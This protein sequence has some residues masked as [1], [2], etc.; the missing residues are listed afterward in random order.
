MQEHQITYNG[1]TLSIGSWA[2]K[3]HQP[4][5][6]LV[7]RY[8]RGWPPAQVLG[9]EPRVR[10]TVVRKSFNR[11]SKRY[12]HDGKNLTLKEWAKKLGI[13]VKTIYNRKRQGLPL[14]MV[15]SKTRAASLGPT[16]DRPKIL[17]PVELLML[18]DFSIGK[19]AKQIRRSIGMTQQKA[20]KL[21]HFARWDYF[22][23]GERSW[24]VE[25]IEKFNLMIAK[26]GK[27]H[28]EST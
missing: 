16:T 23:R 14:D 20:A 17:T 13:P 11:Q 2:Q 10:P 9:Y 12:E 15:F 21:M 26:H 1:L 4:R 24:T 19:M 27:R 22:E 5:H 3:T 25:L 18:D 8:S 6:R 28:D 7:Y